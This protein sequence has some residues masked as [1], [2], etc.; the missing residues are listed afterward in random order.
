MAVPIER[1]A[2]N[3]SILHTNNTSVMSNRPKLTVAI[4]RFDAYSKQVI[5]FCCVNV[6]FYCL[7]IKWG[8]ADLLFLMRNQID[9]KPKPPGEVDEINCFNLLVADSR[10]LYQN[11]NR[12]E[13]A[14]CCL[15]NQHSAKRLTCWTIW[16]FAMISL[17]FGSVRGICVI[18][19]PI[20]V[21]TIVW[22]CNQVVLCSDEYAIRWS[23]RDVVSVCV[24][25]R[26]YEFWM[27]SEH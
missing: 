15:Q 10:L 8:C 21:C 24:K 2:V 27:N 12:N 22:E 6:M 18:V 5:N 3:F 14:I 23:E 9:F 20:I 26:R 7:R 11:I 25:D 4:N 17:C 16:S 13:W 19:F 1:S